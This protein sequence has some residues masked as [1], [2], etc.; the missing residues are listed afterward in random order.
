MNITDLFKKRIKAFY[1]R[2][3]FVAQWLFMFTLGVW[4][5][6]GDPYGLGSASERAGERAVYRLVSG[7]YD[8]SP[9]EQNIL[10]ILFNDRAIDNLYPYL[11]ESNDW[12]LSYLDQVNLLSKVMVQ[13]PKALFYD[14]MW[15]KKRSLDPSYPRAIDKL[16]ALQQSTNVPLYFARGT[17]DS[18]MDKTVQN[19]LSQF[20]TLVVNG[21]EGEG[22]LYPLFVGHDTPTA[23]TILYNNYCQTKGCKPISADDG[24]SMS[25][26][27]NANSAEVLLP[28]RNGECREKGNVLQVLMRV[29]FSVAQNTLPGFEEQETLQLCPPQRVLY[30]DELMAMVRSPNVTERN[31]I[32]SWI[33]NSVVLIGGQ[34][35][36]VHDYV[37]SPVH[38]ALPGVFFHAMALD[39][40]MVFEHD[41]TKEDDNVDHINFIIWLLYITLLIAV[42][43]WSQ[44]VPLFGWLNERLW[45][46]SLAFVS[47]VV[48]VVFGW[49][50][51]AP[52]SW[53]SILA[54]GWVG[55]QLIERIEYEYGI[56]DEAEG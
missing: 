32:K 42:R 11:W 52:S 15:M 12:P 4:L 1:I 41:Y 7:Q 20:A 14:V 26:R 16:K 18:N 35:E 27:W 47:L 48:T 53:I 28:H 55:V 3:T 38:G 2:F 39:N 56:H 45:L 10:V 25:V 19:D 36:G 29:L 8:S 46:L 22:E 6:Y 23:A 50:H 30:A 34:I 51:Y 17:S 37:V 44:A 54:L 24:S 13:E 33:K 5:I 40:L 49:F 9:S 21:W 43:T 31:L